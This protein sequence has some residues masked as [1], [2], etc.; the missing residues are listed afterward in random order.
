MNQ[1]AVVTVQGGRDGATTIWLQAQVLERTLAT[2]ERL[3]GA[4]R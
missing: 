4:M 2:F 1:G 3:M